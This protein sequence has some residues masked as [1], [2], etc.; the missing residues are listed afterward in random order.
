MTKIN[1][2]SGSGVY[3][4]NVQNVPTPQISGKNNEISSGVQQ[5]T[6]KDEFIKQKRKNGLVERA[7]DSAKN[8]TNLGTGSKKVQN[9]IKKAEAGAIS[10]EEAYKTIEKYRKSQVNS[11]QAFGDILSVG[12]AGLTFFNANKISKWT[13]AGVK[14]N[15]PMV[16]FFEGE[17]KKIAEEAASTAGKNSSAQS[18]KFLDSFNN[19]LTTLKSD[20]KMLAVTV[21]ATILTGALVKNIAMQVNRIGSKEFSVDKKDFN[22]ARTAEDKAA[23]KAAKKAKRKERFNAD[24]R[25]ILSGAVNGAM[26]PLGLLGGAIAAPA[27]VV[28]NSLNRFFIGNHEE[29]NKSLSGYMKNLENDSLLHA[30]TAVAMAVPMFNKANWTKTFNANIKKVTENLEKAKLEAPEF[31]NKTAYSELKDVLLG[32]DDIQKAINSSSSIESQAKALIDENIFAAKFKQIDKNDA[33][34]KL[35]KESCPATRTVE[36]AQSY[37]DTALGSGYKVKK[38][39]GVGTVAE[40]YIATDPNGKEVCLKVLKEGMNAE[41][42][43]RDKEKF[44]NIV[45]NMTDKTADQKE[46][47]IRNIEDLSEGIM[48]EVNLQSE[49]DAAIRIAKTTNVAHVVKPIEV[50]NGVYIMEKANG[51]SL[52]SF[53]E[54]NSLYTQKEMLEKSGKDVSEIVKKIEHI[55]SRTPD[56]ENI[57]FNKKDAEYL[58]NEY[59]KVF[60]EQFHKIE[61]GGKTIHGDIHPANIFIDPQ[62]LSSRKGK[63]FTLIDTGNV[64]DMNVEQSLRALNITS[65]IKKGNV[66]DIT[67]YVL[68]GAKFPSGMTKEQAKELMEKELKT[69]FFDNKTKLDGGVS[70]EK[71]LGLADNIMQKYDII[72]GSAQLNLIKTKTSARTSLD[73]LRRSIYEKNLME[74]IDAADNGVVEATSKSLE[75]ALENLA[76][77]K[78][79]DTKVA[80][81]EKQNLLQLTK[82]QVRIQKNNPNNLKDNDVDYLT[83]K[84]KQIML[85]TKDL[86]S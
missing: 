49:M 29:K 81:Q 80:Q 31:N 79:Y 14:V 11:A 83:Y 69:I 63:L 58:L 71:I 1:A 53:L 59:Q 74:I 28:G 43:T 33:L 35:L 47:L 4:N 67:E 48:K 23:Y 26:M 70:E 82:E 56:F 64:I 75:K 45:K 50:K 19:L 15:N 46:Y 54:L 16:K 76:K 77:N 6:L 3:L 52:S 34:G 22:G 41:K 17:F 84:L 65:F 36:Q 8:L 13:T 24:C 37:F 85:D 40:T 55:K 78:A 62:A 60:I 20:K 9:A 18:K 51:I 61:K 27:Y 68:E 5:S 21:G 66:K 39:L 7:Y 12:A 10:Q 72:P 32:S 73:E 44:I 57:K 2:V 25:N 42:I 86:K 30:A 38:L